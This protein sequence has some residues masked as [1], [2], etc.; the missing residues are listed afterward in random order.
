MCGGAGVVI[1]PPPDTRLP[2]HT[3]LLLHDWLVQQPHGASKRN[4]TASIVHHCP[5]HVRPATPATAP[6]PPS[7]VLTKAVEWN[8]GH[9]VSL[10]PTAS[11]ERK[12]VVLAP[13]D[14]DIRYVEV[15]E[16][17]LPL[18]GREVHTEASDEGAFGVGLRA[19]V[20]YEPV[21]ADR[22]RDVIAEHFSQ[23]VTTWTHLE[24]AARRVR[25]GLCGGG[26]GATEVVWAVV[27]VVRSTLRGCGGRGRWLAS[28]PHT[29][30][31][32]PRNASLKQWERMW[33]W[34]MVIEGRPKVLVY[35]W[36]GGGGGGG[37]NGLGRR[38][39]VPPR[40][41]SPIPENGN[42]RANVRL[43]VDNEHLC[44]WDGGG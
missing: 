31:A 21:G 36:G 6:H 26:H 14:L 43:V 15:A 32:A 18:E 4:G 40:A 20:R 2:A 29:P 16:N 41:S 37:G 1:P 35:L 7:E 42:T 22:H 10:E 25:H 17:G 12:M 8:G 39:R 27:W 33:W 9:V 5:T 24:I 11:V 38:V 44:T 3:H 13:T 34:S 28:S 23:A 19:A 30:A